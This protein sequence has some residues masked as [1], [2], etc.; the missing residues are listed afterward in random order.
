MNK[1]FTDIAW[2]D[3]E[4]WQINDRKIL[5]KINELIKDIDWNG[6]EGKGKPE[7]LKHELQGL[8]SRRITAEHRLIY[9]I[10]DKNIYIL[11]CRGHYDD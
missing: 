5:K 2:E 1:M 6:N 10:D 8:W 11:Q 9:K 4:Y 3:Y 7:P